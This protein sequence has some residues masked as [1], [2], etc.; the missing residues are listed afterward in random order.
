[1]TT[2]LLLLVSYLRKGAVSSTPLSFLPRESPAP[3]EVGTDLLILCTLPLPLL[4]LVAK[5]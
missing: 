3:E 1:M 2:L 5:P 4:S